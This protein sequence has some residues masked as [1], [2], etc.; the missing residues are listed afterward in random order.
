MIIE[1]QKNHALDMCSIIKQSIKFLCTADHTNNPNILK[2]WLRNKTTEN[3]KKW[4]EDK[5]S[6]VFI[7]ITNNKPVGVSQIG[8][9]GYIFLC[10]LLPSE[11]GKGVGTEL[12]TA[13]EKEAMNCGLTEI[14]LKSTITAKP[15]YESQGFISNGC[16]VTYD[17]LC[18]Y[19]LIKHIQ[20]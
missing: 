1:A 9:N 19:P 4:I 17:N 5:N 6:Q 15:F 18:S 12:L 10:Y 8:K 14:T 7:A 20:P 3:C 13:C 11:Q 2:P 16:P